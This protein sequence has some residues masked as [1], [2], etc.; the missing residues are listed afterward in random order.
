LYEFYVTW[1]EQVKSR[2]IGQTEDIHPPWILPKCICIDSA[3]VVEL[4]DNEK[5]PS[6]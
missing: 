3:P 5:P 1:E 4:T 2:V 6:S